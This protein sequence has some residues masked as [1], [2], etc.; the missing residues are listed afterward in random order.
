MQQRERKKQQQ[1]PRKIAKR[2]LP[3]ALK[4]AISQDAH[5]KRRRKVKQ[6]N[7]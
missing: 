3:K 4:S 6:V 2:R 1:K 5:L 7:Q